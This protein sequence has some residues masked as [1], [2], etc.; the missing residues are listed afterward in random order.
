MRLRLLRY[1]G[2]EDTPLLVLEN[3]ILV[4]N[5]LGCRRIKVLTKIMGLNSIMNTVLYCLQVA[6]VYLRYFFPERWV[7]IARFIAQVNEGAT[8]VTAVICHSLNG[9]I[10]VLY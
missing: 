3:G 2:R 5:R 6:G 10:Q 8:A 4:T 9:Q 1:L 7:K